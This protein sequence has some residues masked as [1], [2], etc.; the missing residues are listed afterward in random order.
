[1]ICK[2][3]NPVAGITFIVLI[4]AFALFLLIVGFIGNTL[5]TEMQEKMGITT[6]I[7]DSFQTT[8]TTSTVTISALWY[9]MFAGLLLG[10]IVQ[11]M[12]AVQ[13]PKVMVPIFILTLIISVLVAIVLANAYDKVYNQTTLASASAWQYGIYFIMTKLPYIAVIVGLVAIIIMFTRDGSVGGGGGII[14]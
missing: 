2:K 14:N 13:Y 7:N 9:I 12:M 8:I 3:G 5:G 10:L 1:M 6:E 4:S 11:A